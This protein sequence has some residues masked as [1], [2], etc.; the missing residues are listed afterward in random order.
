MGENVFIKGTGK[1]KLWGWLINQ[2]K[3]KGFWNN[4]VLENSTV[5]VKKPGLQRLVPKFVY[6]YEKYANTEIEIVKEM[7]KYFADFHEYYSRLNEANQ[8]NYNLLSYHEVLDIY[9]ILIYHYL[10][11]LL[12]EGISLVI[13]NR[14]YHTSQDF[15]LYKLAKVLNI[16]T[17]IL[18]Q[19]AHQQ[20]RFF[21]VF[22]NEDFG[23]FNTSIKSSN[24]T[25]FFKVERKYEKEHD[26]MISYYE[27]KKSLKGKLT[28][29]SIVQLFIDY[30]KGHNFFSSLYRFKLLKNYKKNLATYAVSEVNL[31]K[32]YIYFALHLQ[33]EMTTSNWGGI[34]CDQVL[35]IEQLSEILPLGWKIYVK[36]NPKQQNFQRSK[37]FFKRLN[38]IDNVTLVDSAFDTYS[39][40]KNSRIAA[41]ITGTVGWEAVTGGK[42]VIIFGFGTWYKTIPGVHLFNK[43]LELEQI[44]N[45][46]IIHDEV[47]KAYNTIM[48]YTHQGVV[49]AFKRIDTPEQIKENREAV[50]RAFLNILNY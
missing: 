3:N 28:N 39:L 29:S 25:E 13:F 50:Y 23:D 5:T 11:L 49:Y 27:K 21:H 47:E 26:Y 46:K 34:F 7:R 22:E 38:A 44:A 1:Q 35:A 18:H 43:D 15:T 20:N 40:L 6:E 17:L 37:Y 33:P 4:V 32:N 48:E 9:N 19:F 10:R 8:N 30:Y 31:S 45:T 14:P 2:L 12:D 36:E 42:P 41:T 24:K 16:K